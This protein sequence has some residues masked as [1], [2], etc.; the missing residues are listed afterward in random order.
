MAG[1]LP[2]TRAHVAIGVGFGHSPHREGPVTTTTPLPQG[3][4]LTPFDPAFREDPYPILHELRRRAP[5]HRDEELRRWVV[6]RHDDVAFVL[7]HKEFLVDPRKARPDAFHRMFETRGGDEEPSMLFLDDPEHKRLRGLVS[8]AFTPRAVEQMR[9][10]VRRL[11]HALLDRVPEGEFDVM[12]ALAAPLPAVAIAMMLGVDE[13]DQERFK[14]WSET[15]NEVFFNP[16]ADAAE[17]ARGQEA[18]EALQRF[19]QDEIRKRRAEP[20]DDLIGGLCRVEEDGDRLS[21][22]EIVT[23]CNL[24]LIAGNVTTTDLIGNGV[25]ALMDHPEQLET[26]RGRTDL[27]PN[28][29]EEMLRYDSPVVNSARIAPYDF[30]LGGVAIGKGESVLTVLGAANRDPEVYPDPDRFD[31]ER[32]D[33]HHQSF[34]GG[35]HLC[36]GAHLARLEAREAIAALLERFPRLEPAARPHVYRQVPSFRG[37]KEYWLHAR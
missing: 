7:R 8:R 37:L 6:T 27:V 20:R 15:S 17:Q 14:T 24:L 34:G 22:A 1:S 21:E 16:F 10:R 33:T 13:A 2:P 30:E 12:A 31:V 5:V 28:A 3:M 26:L 25:K 18:V 35:H 32:E 29:V 19:F 11:A 36:L 23:M 9:P 4:Q